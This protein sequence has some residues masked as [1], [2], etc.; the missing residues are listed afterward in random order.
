MNVAP[1][2]HSSL[3][4]RAPYNE[5]LLNSRFIMENGELRLVLDLFRSLIIALHSRPDVS[6]DSLADQRLN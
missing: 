6:R 1:H 5:A 4:S 2:A 3:V